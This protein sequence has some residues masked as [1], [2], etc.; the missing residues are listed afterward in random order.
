MTAREAKKTY[1]E[2]WNTVYKAVMREVLPDYEILFLRTAHHAALE[3]CQYFHQ[4]VAND[5]EI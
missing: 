1:P 2:L 3:A 5:K 4:K